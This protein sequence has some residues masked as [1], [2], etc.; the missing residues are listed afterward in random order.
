MIHS[1]F[2]IVLQKFHDFLRFVLFCGSQILRYKSF[3]KK[4]FTFPLF[5]IVSLF[6]TF[7]SSGDVNLLFFTEKSVFFS[8]WSTLDL[9][10]FPYFS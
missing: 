4:V 10:V 2:F 9:D 8:V 3:L 7:L 5:L 6:L 1:V